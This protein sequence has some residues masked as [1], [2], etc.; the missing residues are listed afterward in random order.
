MPK[1]SIY[2]ASELELYNRVLNFLEEVCGRRGQYRRGDPSQESM[3]DILALNFVKVV[4]DCRAILLLTQAGFFIQAGILVR[5]TE[6]ACSFMMHIG[7]EG[8]DAVIVEKWLSGQRVTHWTMIK[9]LNECL[10][11]DHRL[12]VTNYRKVRKRLD[13]FVHANF[14]A[15]KLYPAQ[16]PGATPLDSQSLRE[17]TFWKHLVYLYLFS[18][19]LVTEFIVPDCEEK[20]KSYLEQ[21]D[22][23]RGMP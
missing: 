17:M 5:S 20:A 12:N 1:T 15:L 16:S 8:D 21:L 23:L 19:L 11:P 9:K 3:M 13:D 14:D 4:N 6:D 7:F 2:E 22:E 10:P 18:C